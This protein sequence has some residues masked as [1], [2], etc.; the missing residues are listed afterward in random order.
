MSKDNTVV[1]E[2]KGPGAAICKEIDVDELSE[3]DRSVW[4]VPEAYRDKVVDE[5]QHSQ[6]IED[7]EMVVELGSNPRIRAKDEV[8]DSDTLEIEVDSLEGQDRL[9]K[10]FSEEELSKLE[11]ANNNAT[12][13]QSYEEMKKEMKREHDKIVERQKREK[14]RKQKEALKERDWVDPHLSKPVKELSGKE[15]VELMQKAQSDSVEELSES[16]EAI[17]EVAEEMQEDSIE[18]S[19]IEPE[20]AEEAAE[21]FENQGMDYIADD[22]QA[23][24]Q[25]PDTEIYH[26]NDGMVKVKTEN[27]SLVEECRS[28]ASSDKYDGYIE[29]ETEEAVEAVISPEDFKG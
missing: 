19:D 17:E 8:A 9:E 10:W 29:K 3:L 6:E 26:T 11:E 27:S 5:L 18:I 20:M 28:V 21:A 24:S 4:R 22:F 25:V 13:D 12:S 15:F 16:E 14:I 2:Q 7:D 1:V 23:S